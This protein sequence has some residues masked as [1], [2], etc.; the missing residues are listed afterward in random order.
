MH[1]QTIVITMIKLF[2]FITVL[3]KFSNNN[4]PYPNCLFAGEDRNGEIIAM[5]DLCKDGYIMANRKDGL[6]LEHCTL[7]LKEL[8]SFH[9]VSL[10]MKIVDPNSFHAAIGKMHEVVFTENATEYYSHVLESTLNDAISSL[11]NVSNQSGELDK[12]IEI[13]KRLGGERLFSIMTDHV[14]NSSDNWKVACHGDLWINNIMFHYYN[15]K[16]KHVKLVDLQTIRYTNL[17]CDILLFLYSSTEGD[18][19]RKHMDSLIRIYREA[20]IAQLREY[21]EKNY[22]RELATLTKEF[23]FESIKNELAIRSLY[24]EFKHRTRNKSLGDASDNISKPIRADGIR[25]RNIR[26]V[27][28]DGSTAISRIPQSSSRHCKRIL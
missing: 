7:V 24:G 19:R 16:V 26:Q 21:L 18:L 23:T 1:A 17:T 25:F 3:N 4:L 10:A 22:A 20:L 6:D 13:L 12:P 9:A 28:T 11:S 15:N 2:F 27:A 8:A 14:K 5:E